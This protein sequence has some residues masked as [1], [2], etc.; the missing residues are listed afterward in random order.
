MMRVF[1]GGDVRLGGYQALPRT[2]SGTTRQQHAADDTRRG[3]PRHRW[4]LR[5]KTVREPVQQGSRPTKGSC[6]ESKEYNIL[7]SQP[8][9]H[10]G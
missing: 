10:Q 7:G 2:L 6:I 5:G 1:T 9:T 8:I 3:K 4:S